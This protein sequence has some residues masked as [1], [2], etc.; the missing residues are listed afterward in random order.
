MKFGIV[1]C[2]TISKFYGESL[3]HIEGS[4]I[5]FLDDIN[6]QAARTFAEKYGGEAYD[7]YDALLASGIDAVCLC[8]PSGLHASQA[9]RAANAGKHIVCEKPIGIT[10]RQLDDIEAAVRQ[11]GVT[12]TAISQLLFGDAVQATKKALDEGKLGKL[13]LGDVAMKY[14]RSEEYFKAGGW[15][16]TWAMDGGGALMNQGIHGVS[17]LLYLMGPVKSVA[18]LTRTLVHDIEVE[19]TAVALLEFENGALGNLIGTTSVQPA[20]PRLFNIQGENGTIELTEN[21]ISRWEVPGEDGPGVA[22]STVNDSA[23]D[24]TAFTY[25]LHKRQLEDFIDAVQTGRKPLLGVKEGREAVDLI[26]AIYQSSQTGKTI[27]F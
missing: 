7:N 13:V 17:V 2:G 24:P 19:D 21:S 5:A 26:L 9:V 27:T 6:M 23:N 4:Q 18:A 3:N 14:Y 15:R 8:T 1:G 11:N 25:E 16:G 20:M 10:A 12:F 22:V